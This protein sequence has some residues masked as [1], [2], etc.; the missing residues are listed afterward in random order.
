MITY[1]KHETVSNIPD[2]GRPQV[3]KQGESE[4]YEYSSDGPPDSYG[5]P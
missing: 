5:Q 1:G 3:V 2:S 4:G